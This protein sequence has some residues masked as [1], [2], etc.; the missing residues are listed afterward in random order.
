MR[1]IH[2][3]LERLA[4][5]RVRPLPAVLFAVALSSLALGGFLAQS[6]EEPRGARPERMGP[7]D[8]SVGAPW[9][10]EPGISESVSQIM[11]RETAAR[12]QA[13]LGE[14]SA[15]KEIRPELF[16]LKNLPREQNPLA[17]AHSRWPLSPEGVQAA[18]ALNAQTVGTSFLGARISE[19]GFIPPDSMGAVGPTQ[20]VVIVNGR[21][22]VF[23]KS[24]VLGGLNA[25]TDT[26]FQSV[27]N[28]SST[29]DPH[30]RYDRLS[31]RWFI[32][33]INVSTPNRIL[34][35]VSSGSTIT[36]ASSFTFFFFQHDQVGATPNSDTGGLADYDT[37]GVD[38]FA[39][40]IGSNIFN[41]A[42]TAFIG[43]TGYVVNKASLFL[44]T[45]TVTA[46]R[47][48]TNC[49]AGCTAGPLS[50]Q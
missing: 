41:A 23:D 15:P 47:G 9:T 50:P 17:P 6:P 48:L 26:F 31:G 11:A 1:F 43:T 32:T 28:N 21:I 40:Y 10:G 24:G 19:S 46:F 18:E 3:L 39:L 25:S 2:R 16:D 13:A 33:I 22:K 44:G 45:L 7:D 38:R 35:A 20:V 49:T 12:A 29:S 5:A 36:S 14:P 27:R 37:L 30:V 34:I 8:V 42:G 4:A